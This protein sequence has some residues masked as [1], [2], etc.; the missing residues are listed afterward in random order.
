MV[1][2]LPAK[3]LAAVACAAILFSLLFSGITFGFWPQLAAS[4]VF[5]C[6][7]SSAFDFPGTQSVFSIPKG[8]PWTMIFLVGL[9][10]AGFLYGVFFLGNGIANWL[11]SFSSSQVNSIYRLKDGA[12][13]W[14]PFLLITLFIGPAEEVFWRGYVQ[15]HLAH[16]Y[17]RFGL[18][19]AIAA[20]TGVHV[21]S[22]NFM[23][24][25]AAGACGMFWGILYDRFRSI[26][27]NIV[28]HVAWDL[29]AFLLWPFSS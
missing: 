24:I 5:L 22:G 15:R 9:V 29:S 4:A 23:L 27:I 16:R 20:Y 1:T 7:L 28:S 8:K 11:F 2:Y 10:S 25:A 12:G 6:L 18:W 13:F 19:L 17:R 14:K 3:P 26:W 21:A